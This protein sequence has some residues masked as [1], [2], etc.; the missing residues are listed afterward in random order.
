[1]QRSF[2]LAT[3]VFVAS[4][5]PVPAQESPGSILQ[6]KFAAAFNRHDAAAVASLFARDGIRVTPGGVFLG[7]EAIQR[8]VQDAM[9]AGFHDLSGKT[10]VSRVSGDLVYDQ[11]EWHGVIGQRQLRGYYSVI[12]RLDGGQMHILEETVNVARPDA[13]QSPARQ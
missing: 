3:C 1:M 7:R 8:Q 12:L 10:M 4:A 11:G 9:D 6:D 13:S 2:A 5:G